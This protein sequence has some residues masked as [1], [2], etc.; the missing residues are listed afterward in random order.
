MIKI[1]ARQ[2]SFLLFAVGLV[3]FWPAFAQAGGETLPTSDSE[4]KGEIPKPDET[5]DIGTGIF[6]RLPF[7]VSASVRGGYDDNVFTTHSDREGSSFT[8][9]EVGVTYEFG[10]PRTKLSVGAAGGVTYYFDRP[11]DSTD[12]NV[13]LNLSLT[14]KATSRLAF[15]AT[16]Y[17]SYQ[18]EP[19]FSFALGLNRRNGDFFYTQ[20]K[21][22]ATYV[23]APRF[24]TAT[25]YTLG[26]IR[27]DNSSI[28]FFEDRF[29][30]T[31]GNEFRFLLWPTTALVG[32]YRYEIVSYD[33]VNR[34]SG[35]HFALAG[36]DQTFTP[37]LNASVRGGV[38]FREY[39]DKTAGANRA[40]PYFETTVNYA[41]GKNTSITWTNRYSIEESD[42]LL[43]P[44]R[45][46]FRTGLRA[47]H[48]FTPRISASLDAFFQHDDYHDLTKPVFIAAGFTEESVDVAA[49]L[50]YAVTRILG[51]EAG[52]NHTE[53]ISDITLREYSRNRFF[54]GLNLAF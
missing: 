41:L 43:N 34:D 33:G 48:N 25:S 13:S 44:G 50:R 11:G 4:F 35:S 1:K 47:K 19:D 53:V 6:S 27:Y 16:V 30:N 42:V 32:E 45:D 23:W 8:N 40:S 52:Y 36:I 24:A 22:T 38:E 29:E 18:S 31:F 12:T 54:A 28:A 37:R 10:S 26:A 7:R 5:D 17:A 3:F 46:T 2:R 14:H 20:D 15:A 9:A 49:S 21:F 39:R 51:I